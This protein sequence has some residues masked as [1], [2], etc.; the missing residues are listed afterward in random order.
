[1]IRDL[2]WE[3]GTD[4]EVPIIND[5]VKGGFIVKFPVEL[6][7]QHSF[8]QFQALH[9]FSTSVVASPCI[10]QNWLNL[11]CTFDSIGN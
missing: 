5:D 8:D 9:E 7:V 3:P 4:L 11:F 10:A 6:N 2:K 1:M